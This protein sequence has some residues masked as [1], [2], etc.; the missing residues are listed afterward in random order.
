MK[1]NLGETDK[2]IRIILSIIIAGIGTYFQS[3]W[4]LL[5]FIPLITAFINYCPLYGLFGV[6]SYRH[7]TKTK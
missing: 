4:G 7:K 2:V 6:S 5:A 3:W 1:R